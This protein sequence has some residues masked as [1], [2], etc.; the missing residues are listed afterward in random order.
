MAKAAKQIVYRYNGDATTEEIEDDRDGEIEVHKHG[1]I[2][3]RNGT[4]WKVVL[5]TVDETVAG[6]KAI[7]V[8]RI[9]LTDQI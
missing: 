1:E 4:T 9:Y 5:V 2:V 7:P 8:V 3:K 6:P